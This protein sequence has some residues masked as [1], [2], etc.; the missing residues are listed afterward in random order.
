MEASP[1]AEGGKM[2]RMNTLIAAGVAALVLIFP[3]AATAHIDTAVSSVRAHTSKADTALDRAVSLFEANR[4][5]RGQQALARS[6]RQMG[7]A[8]S[9]TAK[10]LRQAKRPAARADAA[11]AL[12]I[13]GN[14]R[15]ANVDELLGVLDEARGKVQNRVAQAALTDTRGRDKAIS[16]LEELLE[17]KLPS[18]AER[19]IVR[20]MSAL[21]QDRD[22]E[23]ELAAEALA[24]N[25]VSRKSKRLVVAT[26]EQSVDGQ[27]TA[28]A[29]LAELIASD[30][31]PEQSKLGLSRA[32]D[33]VIGE[34][35]SIADTLTQFSDR[36]P[37]RIRAFVEQIV[38]LAKENAQSL[39]DDRPD[40]PT[41]P[42][43]TPGGDH[44]PGGPPSET[45]TV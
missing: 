32:Y 8:N 16:I 13:L 28:A 25:R 20:A 26:V 45:P 7:K 5:R 4:N 34:L 19:G 37:G 3:T 40:P 38:E 15:D 31:M 39:R 30:E 14:Q 12:R 27:A 6:R 29:R 23:V 9:E 22:G 1:V 42:E 33:A 44:A 11:R 36:M 43:G 24:S 18:Q 35:E 17:T 2:T 21:A 10:L 41:G